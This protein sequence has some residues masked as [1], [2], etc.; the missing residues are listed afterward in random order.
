MELCGRLE[1]ELLLERD[2]TLEEVDMELGMDLAVGMEVCLL[3][4]EEWVGA[5]WAGGGGRW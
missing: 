1:L 5:P 3:G 2:L 4:E